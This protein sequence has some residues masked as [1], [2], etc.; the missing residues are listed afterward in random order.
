MCPRLSAD[1]LNTLPQTAPTRGI[2]WWPTTTTWKQ[3]ESTTASRC[4]LSLLLCSACGVPLS[5]NK[6]AGGEAVVW[7]GFELLH[8]THHLGISQRRAER[9]TKWAREVADSDQVHMARF[10][11]G[12]G[13]RRLSR[14]TPSP[15]LRTQSSTLRQIL[16][17][18]SGRSG[19]EHQAPQLRSSRWKARQRHHGKTH[20]RAT[21][22]RGS[23]DG[24]CSEDRTARSMS[25]GHDGFHSNSRKRAGLGSIPGAEKLRLSS[26]LLKRSLCLWR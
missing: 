7:V 12:L 3:E 26:R 8:S 13:L 18:L 24:S 1:C 17:S 23:E 16:P 9:F 15:V 4:S 11:E 20:R 2:W 14:V 19:L 6:T 22:G 25:E 5:W 21:R 10:E